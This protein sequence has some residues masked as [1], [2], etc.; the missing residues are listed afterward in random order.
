[1]AKKEEDLTKLSTEELIKRLQ[2][3]EKENAEIKSVNEDLISQNE[4]LTVQK[5]GKFPVVKDS[6]G[7]QYQVTKHALLYQPGE[8]KDNL[9][10]EKITAEDLAADVKL[11]DLAVS[12]KLSI[13]EPVKS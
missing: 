7:K 9:P 12:K 1:M 2:E 11:V 6:K 3:K 10:L 5:E 8:E 4:N 13:L